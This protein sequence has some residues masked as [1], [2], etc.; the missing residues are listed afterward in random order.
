MKKYALELKPLAR[1]EAV[2]QGEKYRFTV[3][4]DC[5]IRMEY[6]EEGRFVDE[7]TK[8]VI[9]RDFPVPRFRV[10][11]REDSL[12]IATEKLHDNGRLGIFFDFREDL[13]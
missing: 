11:D 8:T 3:L 10:I 2:V 7:S 1:P 5:L 12:E 4:T 9:C 6:Q 13:R